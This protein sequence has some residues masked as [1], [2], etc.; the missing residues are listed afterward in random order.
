LKTAAIVV[1]WCRPS[2]T[3]VALT[4]LAS[5]VPPPDLLIC[6]ENG[7]PKEA[8][9]A[10]RS[11]APPT[12]KL[13]SLPDNVGFPAGVNAGMEIALAH[14]SEWVLLLNNDAVAFPNCLVRCLADAVALR[15]V[16]AVGPAISFM[17]QPDKL[18]YGGGEVSD[19]FAFTRHR[20]LMGATS[21]PPATSD[22]AFV[23]WC[24]LSLIH[25]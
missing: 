6:I 13:V 10:V 8:V 20:G 25:I 14:E 17:E 23:T 24:C 11:S 18:W 22:T 1:D 7:S 4:S 3:V 21:H 16:A 19:W 9:D 12:T 15:A 2:D 5:M